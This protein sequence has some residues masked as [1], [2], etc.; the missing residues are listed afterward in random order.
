MKETKGLD[1][2]VSAEPGVSELGPGSGL[3]GGAA[4]MDNG[5]VRMSRLD[6]H[7]WSAVIREIRASAS[8]KTITKRRMNSKRMGELS[9][10]A[11]LL[12]ARTLGLLVSK[13]W[14]DSE[15]YDFVVDF[16]GEL[17]RVQVK[18]TGAVHARGY[19]V[20]AIYGVYGKRKKAYTAKDIDALVVHIQPRDVWYVIPVQAF[21][22]GKN[23]RFYPD[24]RCWCARWE[25]YR[26]AWKL[27][28][29]DGGKARR[30]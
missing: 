19:E 26:E 10:A 30:H 7:D 15:K 6:G 9:E 21:A 3:S 14:G 5:M 4:L 8:N 29:G 11:F 22:P 23:L 24:I 20:Q 16:D 27:L 1:A 28:R 25:K 12:K 18:C 17:W 2:E 13:P